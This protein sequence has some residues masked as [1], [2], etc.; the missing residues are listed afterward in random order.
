M[1]VRTQK[2]RAGWTN[3]ENIRDNENKLPSR[4]PDTSLGK[5]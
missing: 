3:L 5:M 1:L 4:K 2:V